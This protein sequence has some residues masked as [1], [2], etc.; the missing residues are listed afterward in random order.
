MRTWL[1]GGRYWALVLAL[2][3]ATLAVGLFTAAVVAIPG[4]AERYVWNI[5][6]S[7][8]PSP[9]PATSALAPMRI[10]IPATADCVGCHPGGQTMVATIPRMAHPVEGWT[11]C[12]ACH[13]DD[14]LVKTAPGHT[15]IHKELCLS[16]HQP[17]GA[18]STALPRPHH[19]VSDKA[20]IDCHGSQAP[21]PT[22]MT[23][24]NN[25][26]ICHAGADTTTLFNQTAP[27]GPGVDVT[28]A[29]SLPPP[30]LPSETF[31]TTPP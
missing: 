3:G 12:T 28:P 15:G 10:P 27:G 18:T 14:K 22:D 30:S 8:S 29:P 31:A 4:F 26:W 5:A 17:A 11:D 19:V 21:L 7:P 6:P 25:C 24:R 13:A 1:T 23:G 16:C 9:T 20:C 2:S